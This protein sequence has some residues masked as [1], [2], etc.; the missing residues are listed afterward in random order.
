MRV[1]GALRLPRRAARVAHG[2]SGPLVD[3]AIA[4]VIRF[5]AREQLL[6][7]DRAVR[8]G[9]VA[10]RDH[11]LEADALAEVLDERPEHLVR[12]QHP[13]ARMGG[14]VGQVVGVQAEVERVRDHSADRDADVDLE[15]LVVV[16]GEGS[17]AVAVLQA[18]LV[19]QRRGEAAGSWRELRVR[20]AMPASVGKPG[21]DLPVAEELLAA[22]QD[23]GHVE[24]VIHDQAFHLSL[25]G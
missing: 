2:R 18:E 9:A 4:E 19:A 25:L 23:R 14:D 20:V 12:D 7:L 21:H 11:V 1:H 8:R 3:L 6:V 13:V 17:D 16:P 15:V 22:A 10:D 5:G 24:L